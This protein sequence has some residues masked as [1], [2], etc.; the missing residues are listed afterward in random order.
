MTGEKADLCMGRGAC[1]GQVR[2]AAADACA[3][4]WSLASTSARRRASS[5][6]RATN[7]AVFSMKLPLLE[8]E[9]LAFAAT[10]LD[11]AKR[12]TGAVALFT[13]RYCH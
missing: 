11:L 2:S 12:L 9:F 7:A 4:A 6:M 13:I 1:H 3:S 10:I 5:F 8:R